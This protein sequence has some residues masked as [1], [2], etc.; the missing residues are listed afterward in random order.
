MQSSAAVPARSA[1]S[2]L[3]AVTSFVLMATLL[4]GCGDTSRRPTAEAAGPSTKLS[5]SSSPPLTSETSGSAVATPQPRAR[6][7]V[8]T[9]KSDYGTVLFDGRG[10]AIYLFEKERTD[11]PACYGACAVA[12]PPVLTGG[13]PL[14]VRGA[15]AD[16]LGTTQRTDGT[17]QVTYANH[18]LYY[19]VND[20][21]GQILCHN[22]TEFGG[23]WLVVT[24]SGDPAT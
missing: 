2:A 4:V 1:R 20:G 13:R 22:V 6:L 14:A 16:L 10:Q 24:P 7:M 19:Y 18:P 9:R 5:A 15:R 23:L 3:A 12:W 8:T 21:R 17:T 11:R